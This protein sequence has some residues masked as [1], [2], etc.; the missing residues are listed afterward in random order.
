MRQSP[1]PHIRPQG[2]IFREQE[3][4]IITTSKIT[5]YKDIPPDRVQFMY[6]EVPQTTFCLFINQSIVLKN[7]Q[8][9]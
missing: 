3:P 1:A 8:P 4:R 9:I 5:I 7:K 2:Y 6:E